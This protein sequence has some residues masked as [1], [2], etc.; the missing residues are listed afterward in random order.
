MKFLNLFSGV[1]QN[2]HIAL[3]CS[4]FTKGNRDIFMDLSE[5]SNINMAKLRP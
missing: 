4:M 2:K 5:L 1:V 3:C